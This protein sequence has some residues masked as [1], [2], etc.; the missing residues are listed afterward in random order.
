MPTRRLPKH[1]TLAWIRFAG[2]L[3]KST[4]KFTS[5]RAPKRWQNFWEGWMWY[6]SVAQDK[7]FFMK[8]MLKQSPDRGSAGAG[9]AIK[10][11]SRYWKNRLVPRR[12]RFAAP[13][14]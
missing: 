10:T 14:K 12:Y 2:T 3:S 11:Q 8:P 1:S 4:R 6:E 7:S 9:P 5:A 13:G